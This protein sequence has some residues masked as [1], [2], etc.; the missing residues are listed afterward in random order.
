[1]WPW[2]KGTLETRDDVDSYTEAVL[3]QILTGATGSPIPNATAAM[4]ICAGLWARG[5]ASAAVVPSNRATRSLTAPILAHIGRQLH[6]CGQ[7][8]L[9]IAVVRGRLELH[10][11]SSWTVEGGVDPSTWEWTLTLPGPSETVTRPL[12][13]ARVLNLMYSHEP[14]RP[15]A[16]VGPLGHAKTSMDLLDRI[17]TR[18]SE[19]MGQ[20][21]GAA[22]PVPNVGTS[23][24]LQ[25][26]LRKLKGELVLVEGMQ[27]GWGDPA[28]APS[29]RHQ[30]WQARRLG[31][32]P[33]DSLRTLRADVSRAVLAASGVPVSL[34]G[35]SDGTLAREGWR[36]FLLGTLAP[37]GRI[38]GQA[39]ADGLDSDG[40]LFDWEKV[41]A[42]DITG[43]ARAFQS[44]VGG[45]MTVEKA[46]ALSGLVLSDD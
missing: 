10:A 12:H 19:E 5:F 29:Q 6:S 32:N 26:D 30:D 34:L 24:Q 22:L 46:A 15:W 37:V 17:E 28:A 11:A 3:Q 42:S 18:L 23:A 7:A 25:A 33:P 16:G 45:G 1:M 36:Q 40:L 27:S 35:D 39:L 13:A 20:P 31:G 14:G 38:V 44:L 43:R 41:G 8:V 9:E 4:E 21:V 2:S